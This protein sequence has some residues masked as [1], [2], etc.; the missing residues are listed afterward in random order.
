MSPRRGTAEAAGDQGERGRR[1]TRHSDWSIRDGAHRATERTQLSRPRGSGQGRGSKLMAQRAHERGTD[2]ARRA[3]GAFKR[4]KVAKADKR[5]VARGAR[6]RKRRSSTRPAAA[7]EESTVRRG[8]EERGEQR[9]TKSTAQVGRASSGTE[10][11][12]RCGARIMD[13][14]CN[15]A[16]AG[17]G[18]G[19]RQ[20]K[21]F[22]TAV[23]PLVMAFLPCGG[24]AAHGTNV[25]CRPHTPGTDRHRDKR[26]TCTQQI[27]L[28]ERQLRPQGT[29]AEQT[30]QEATNTT[31]HRQ[32]HYS[33]RNVTV[34]RPRA[35]RPAP[36]WPGVHGPVR[37]RRPRS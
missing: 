6:T 16:R 25:P 15:T 17:Q 33:G 13:C 24:R 21:T 32:N 12:A 26:N 1:V 31:K 8:S 4:N 28:R 2:D 22:F 20:G 5:N 7:W 30:N 35:H 3:E 9:C 27:R 23:R 36:S 37:G 19:H 34:N 11:A 14:A 10:G 29:N 18:T